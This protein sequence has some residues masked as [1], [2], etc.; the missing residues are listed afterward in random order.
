MLLEDYTLAR[1]VFET[2]IEKNPTFGLNYAN[3]GQ[4]YYI[5]R[6]F[7]RAIREMEKAVS[8]GHSSEKLFYNLGFSYAYLQ[9]CEEAMPWLDR[10]LTINPDS[11]LGQYGVQLCS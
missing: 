10:A 7:E 11:P 9:Q 8:F 1:Q 5:Q 4:I 3:L 6:N 2:G